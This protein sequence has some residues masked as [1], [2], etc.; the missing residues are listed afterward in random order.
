MRWSSRAELGVQIA[1]FEGREEE[2]GHLTRLLAQETTRLVLVQAM[3][4]MGKTWFTRKFYSDASHEYTRR[5]WV[6][7]VNAPDPSQ[8]VV[9]VL[10]QFG[11]AVEPDLCTDDLLEALAERLADA[12]SL[13]VLDNFETALTAGTTQPELAEAYEEFFWMVTAHDKARLILTSREVPAFFDELGP[14]HACTV[15][16]DGLDLSS[17]RRILGPRGV[18]G[19]PGD[20]KDLS[21]LYSGN[22]Q[23]LRLAA[24]NISA[25]GGDIRYFLSHHV[26]SVLEETDLFE[27]HVARTRDE[28]Q[29]ILY[30]LA[31]TRDP[32]RMKDL[33]LL[34]WPRHS[35]GLGSADILRRLRSRDLV[36]WTEPDSLSLQPAM[37][38][39][40]T[41]RLMVAMFH[42]VAQLLEGQAAVAPTSLDSFALSLGSSPPY[43]RERVREELVKPL[44]SQLE[45]TVGSRAALDRQ[46]RGVF[47]SL[48]DSE[49]LKAGY[50]A[51]NI[52]TLLI[53]RG[54]PLTGLD[55]SGLTFRHWDLSEV[56]LVDVDLTES[57]MVECRFAHTFG[58]MLCICGTDS[59]RLV[60]AGGTDNRVWI[61]DTG[62]IHHGRLVGHANWVRSV[63]FSPDGSLLAS[64]SSD[65]TLRTW[66]MDDMSAMSEHV[67][68][69][70]RLWSVAW[71]DDTTIACGDED[72]YLHLVSVAKTTPAQALSAHQGRLMSLCVVDN[73]GLMVTGGTDGFARLWHVPDLRQLD[74]I[75]LGAPVSALAWDSQGRRV[76]IAL[77]DGRVVRL[78]LKDRRLSG[79]RNLI[80][81][82]LPATSIAVISSSGM[83]VVGQRDG[84]LT[85][86]DLDTGVTSMR[87]AAHRAQLT[88]V[89]SLDRTILSTGEDQSIKVWD[90]ESGLP[91][92]SMTGGVNHAWSLATLRAEDGSE[93][94]LSAHEDRR[95]RVWRKSVGQ[96]WRESH[97]LAGHQNRI[98]S[99]RAATSRPWAIS[100]SE[101]CSARVWEI[102][103]G[104]C[105]RVLPAHDG[106]V[107]G[108]DLTPDAATAVTGGDEGVA[109]AWSVT[110]GRLLWSHFIGQVRIRA[111][112]CG[113]EGDWCAV[114]AEDSRVHV[115]RMRDGALTGVFEGHT[116][117][118]NALATVDADRLV[119]GSRDGTARLW[120]ITSQECEQVLTPS[121]RLG[122]VWAVAAHVG[123][124]WIAAGTESG[125]ITLWR[126][127]SAEQR[128]EV[129]LFK[130]RV[131]WVAPSL[132]GSALVAC[133]ED[134][135]ILEIDVASGEPMG[136]AG[137]PRVYEGLNIQSTTGLDLATRDML[138][139]LGAIEHVG[140]V[141]D[142]PAQTED[143]V[144]VARPGEGVF[145]SYSRSDTPFAK[146][147]AEDLKGRGLSVFFDLETLE[148][149]E[150]FEHVIR[151]AI[152]GARLVVL[153]MSPKA[154]ASRWVTRERLFAEECGVPILPILLAGECFF[155]LQDVH[156]E[157]IRDTGWPSGR[158]FESVE[159]LCR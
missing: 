13:I 2:L 8:C 66:R 30:W 110:D 77:A 155:G 119:T 143:W 84:A 6:S 59:R 129:G 154:E 26:D 73:G 131:K 126:L 45:Q 7:L 55:L 104:R 136:R 95:L 56:N 63:A 145:L 115:L 100:A 20:W 156:Y 107:W 93:V 67:L 92:A 47:A 140:V 127:S 85:W 29:A 41:K 133:S 159:T 44:I 108:A 99:V 35:S 94:I 14:P 80:R 76:V 69:R 117:R 112:A 72:G 148:Y 64:V 96:G 61:W 103:S 71:L 40:L 54:S 60:A 25:L 118:V 88:S 132:R 48:R 78:D 53:E 122:F 152:K 62:G 32:T 74:E 22:P 31:L 18:S 33:E 79:R 116:D 109:R 144:H 49:R 142:L 147:V 50:A 150:K 57:D 46:L 51:T 36:Q 9:S 139:E 21:E 106:A 5:A 105:V 120:R 125:A 98:W 68:S 82:G 37:L 153:I 111:L 89:S 90:G 27:W 121:A 52:A 83:A 28:E 24:G 43:V 11:I 39:F 70:K 135:D 141:D 81:E 134:G 157:D 151:E 42:A 16:L 4:G 91:L 10:R 17:V 1:G 12:P 130:A 38:A 101:D 97:A 149:G 86:I 146:A 19:E 102:E 124:D 75:Q 34:L 23:L 137:S 15:K 123:S 138:R 158:F 128:W 113:P 87:L 58:N 3:G 65:S 114:G